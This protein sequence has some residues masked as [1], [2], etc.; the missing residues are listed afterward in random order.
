M[1]QLFHFETK[2]FHFEMIFFLL[3]TKR[4]PKNKLRV[5]MN[6]NV[7]HCYKYFQLTKIVS[8]EIKLIYETKWYLD[9]VCLFF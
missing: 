5:R 3:E 8:Y 2:T 1:L 9:N 4:F 7:L 6:K